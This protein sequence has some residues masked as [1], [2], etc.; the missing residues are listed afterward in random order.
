MLQFY[1]SFTLG[2]LFLYT[3]ISHNSGSQVPSKRFQLTIS[4]ATPLR[5]TDLCSNS[6]ISNQYFYQLVGCTWVLK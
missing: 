5:L 2:V 1:S 4:A 3:S 6:T